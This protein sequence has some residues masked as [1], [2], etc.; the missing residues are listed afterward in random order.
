MKIEKEILKDSRNVIKKK[1]YGNCVYQIEFIQDIIYHI[2]IFGKQ[3]DKRRI[4]KKTDC[5]IFA[6][7]DIAEWYAKNVSKPAKMPYDIPIYA[8]HLIG[9]D[10]ISKYG[11]F[12]IKAQKSNIIRRN[13]WLD[14]MIKPFKRHLYGDDI[15][16]E[17]ALSYLIERKYTSET[18]IKYVLEK[19]DNFDSDCIVSSYDVVA[20]E[21]IPI[22]KIKASNKELEELRAIAD[23]FHEDQMAYAKLTKKLLSK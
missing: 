8:V 21:N 13:D 9:D 23:R 1:N 18:C 11:H 22:D 10:I 14:F 19:C 15:M 12:V 2:T 6:D 17:S 5:L 3:F 7:L 4:S 16:V 20:M